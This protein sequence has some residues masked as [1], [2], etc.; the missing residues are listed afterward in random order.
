MFAAYWFGNFN[1][2][3]HLSTSSL[4]LGFKWYG[5]LGLLRFP[6]TFVLASSKG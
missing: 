3:I 5:A 1:A 4:S 6:F 2:L